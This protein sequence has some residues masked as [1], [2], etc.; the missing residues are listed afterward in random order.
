MAI[1]FIPANRKAGGRTLR[2]ALANGFNYFHI[3]LISTFY[4]YGTK[5][6]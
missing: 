1:L 4:V 3:N 2:L 5:E 6:K